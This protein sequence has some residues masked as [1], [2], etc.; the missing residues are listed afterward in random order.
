[1]RT[2]LG[3]CLIVLTAASGAGRAEDTYRVSVSSEGEQGNSGS[4]RAA[5]S[6]DGRC[7]GFT[8]HADEL[9]RDDNNDVYDVFVY[10]LV[11]YTLTRVSVTESGEEGN[12][13]STS[14]VLSDNGRWVAYVSEASNLV[15]DDTNAVA[16]IFVHD[17]YFRYNERV[18]VASDGTE[19]N[20]QSS[21]PAISANGRFVVFQSAADNLVPD[22][23]DPAGG[24]FMHDRNT[25]TTSRVAVSS[26]G[27]PAN[28]WSAFASVSRDGRFVAFM[29]TA[30]NL[31]PDD[32]NGTRDV[33]V[34]DTVL[35]TTMRVSLAAD[36]SQA[37]EPCIEPAIS[38]DG[39]WVAFVTQDALVPEDQNGYADIYVR[40]LVAEQTFRV[41]VATNGREVD[42]SSSSPALSGDGRF[43]VFLSEATTLVPND[44]NQA[45]DIFVH[46]R[47]TH[48]TRR[49]NL[50]WEDKEA[51]LG[52]WGPAISGDGLLLAFST[53]ADNLVPLDTNQCSD[54]FLRN[55]TCPEPAWSNYGDGWP[56]TYGV[57]IFVSS[58]PP[59][60]CS[61]IALV[62]G[63]SR[64]APTLAL[65]V[66]GA[67]ES[68]LATPWG[69]TLLVVPRW[70]TVLALP[71]S[72]MVERIRVPCGRYLCAVPLR[73]QVLEI[74]P[75]AS[76]GVS[77]T[78]GLELVFGN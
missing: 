27:E 75:R 6:G 38:A 15:P 40:D 47:L 4:F 42:A 26:T 72:G 63:N 18:S 5:V 76:A 24:V 74:D 19:A 62:L 43:V 51:K 66:V 71:E 13:Q 28:G 16:D 48:V 69:G 57:P 58:A 70:L 78:R 8:S 65:L 22:G 2:K 55:A 39:A 54:V 34:R 45:A 30:S 36:G 41:S 60:L 33:F 44:R 10:D 46:D 7:V 23:A 59:E 21:R 50:T 68:S 11:R 20:A 73:M 29:S 52:C 53:E 37:N 56:G 12:A 9:V 64:G 1:M 77:F 25:H 49:V 17:T 32:T 61:S 67:I 35:G 14:P 3:F 31:V